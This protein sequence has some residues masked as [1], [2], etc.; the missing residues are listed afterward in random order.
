MGTEK[1]QGITI[2]GLGPGQPGQLTMQAWQWLQNIPE[3][4]LRTGQHPVV[5][6]FPAGLIVHTFDDIYEQSE[7]F[8]DVYREIVQKIITLGQQPGG[9]TYAVPGHPFVAEATSPEIVKQAAELSIPCRVI[10]GISFLEPT[11][12]ALRIDP[13]PNLVLMDAIELSQ[14]HTPPFP[15]NSPVL[16]A[17]IYSREI[18]ADVKLTL[19]A[20]YPDEYPVQLVHA[21]GTDQERVENLH[22]FE[23]DRSQQ[24][25]LLSSL[26]LPPRPDPTSFE[27]FQEVVA[28]LRA[29]DGCPWDREQTHL[30]LRSSL[31]EETYET[32]AALDDEDPHG[33]QEEFGDL[34]LQIVL[35]AQIAS[36]EGDFNMADVLT[37]I[38]TKIVRRHPHVFG[39]TE[40]GDVA[41]V[42]QNWEKLK[43][44]ERKENGQAETKGMLDGV[45]RTFPAL[46]QALQYQER[47]AR[48][49]FDWK[50]IDGVVEKVREELG[51][52]LE[53]DDQA[54]R[55]KEL[56]DLL[57]AVVNLARWYKAD[58][59]TILR[60]TNQRFR[61]RFKYIEDHARKANRPLSEMALEEMDALWEEA[62]LLEKKE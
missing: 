48:V 3:I 57:F 60:T 44:Q 37:G 26:Y 34:L 45:P 35:H 25:G 38:H 12:T 28:R 23:I 55:E 42:L 18:A 24:I 52:V 22:L 49:G 9:V 2:I 21:A 58:P 54:Q 62:K 29:P 51:E 11:F 1:F 39:D 56:G 40:V 53:S 50:E 7:K 14:R 41:G 8:E 6:D 17:Q 36:E 10:E 5:S 30:S 33:M 46:A 20:A 43:A 31:L 16:I 19:M 4:Y 61:T 13:Y 32:L 47:A 27:A 59:E 15:P